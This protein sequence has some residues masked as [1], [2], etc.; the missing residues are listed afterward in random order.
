M[1]GAQNLM[2]TKT[3]LL[4]ISVFLSRDPVNMAFWMCDKST[5]SIDNNELMLGKVVYSLFQPKTII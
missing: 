5:G 3:F 4:F 2:N 1:N